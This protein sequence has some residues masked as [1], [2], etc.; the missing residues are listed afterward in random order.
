MATVAQLKAAAAAKQAARAAGTVV[1]NQSESIG[2]FINRKVDTALR[3]MSAQ[4]DLASA[5]ADARKADGV[6]RFG[7]F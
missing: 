3:G 2:D 7:L 4:R 6:R 1:T 5:Y